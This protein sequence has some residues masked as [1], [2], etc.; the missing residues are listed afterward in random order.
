MTLATTPPAAT[1][2]NDGRLKLSNQLCFATYAA[3]HAFSRSTSHCWI[4]WG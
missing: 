2:S 4:R 3:A 1:T